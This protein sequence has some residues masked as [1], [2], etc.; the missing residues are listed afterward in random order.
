[1]NKWLV[2]I[3]AAVAAAG[4]IAVD[5]Q[6]VVGYQDKPLGNGEITWTCP[7]FAPV[8]TNT[9]FTLGQLV[10]ND[11]FD[12]FSDT[13]QFCDNGGNWEEALTYVSQAWLDGN[14]IGEEGYTVGWY[15]YSD[16][17]LATPLNDTVVPFAKGFAA[18]AGREGVAIRFSGEVA[19]DISE[20]SLGNGEITWMGNA[21]VATNLLGSIKGNDTFDAFSDTIQFC[22]NGG[23]WE[24]AL[25]YVSQA[26]L[27]GNDIGEEGYTVG[28]YA[29]SDEELTT[30]LNDTVVPNGKAFAAQAGRNGVTITI[31]SPMQASND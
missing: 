28:W 2:S 22:D 10:A 18:Q 30:P 6:N 26:W 3:S 12:A 20:V 17:E 7:T 5:S 25:T 9:S 11:I 29:Y 1:M 21:S 31:P 19:E 13:I 24:E 15:A 8:G 27:D 14:D 4:A 23:N 16:E